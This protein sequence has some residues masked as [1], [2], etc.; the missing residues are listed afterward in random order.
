MTQFKIQTSNTQS[1]F[2]GTKYAYLPAQT[3]TINYGTASNWGGSIN[4]NVTSVGT[5]GNP[6]YYGT[7]DQTG[8]VLEW[9]DLDQTQ[10]TIKGLRGPKNL[11]RIYACQNNPNQISNIRDTNFAKDNDDNL[12]VN[13]QIVTSNN[14][15]VKYSHMVNSGFTPLAAANINGQNRIVFR[16]STLLL[17]QW[18]LNSN[19]ALESSFGW[20]SPKS[21]AY[22]RTESVFETDFDGD[23]IV[24]DPK[25]S[26]IISTIRGLV[27]AKDGNNNLVANGTPVTFQNV[28]VNYNYM[29]ST[30]FTPLAAA[31]INGQN[32]IVFRTNLNFLH[33]WRL[34]SNWNFESSF[35]WQ[36]EGTTPY[37]RSESSFETD[38]NGDGFVPK[39]MRI[40]TPACSMVGG[41][42]VASSSNPGNFFFGNFVT[43]GNP[44]NANDTTNYGQVNYTFLITKYTITNCE[45]IEFL[46]AVASIQDTYSL[47][48]TNMTTDISGGII[49]E[50]NSPTGKFIYKLKNTN[51][52][53]KP[54]TCLTWFN[55]A[56]YCN[57]LHNGKPSIAVYPVNQNTITEDGSY[58][59]NSSS[60][61]VAPQKNS[62]AKYWIP[63]ENEW[64]KA[65]YYDPTLNG[66]N[67]WLF[68][69]RSNNMPMQAK[70]NNIG[71]G[72]IN[73][74]LSSEFTGCESDNTR[75]I[76][77]NFPYN[78]NS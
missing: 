42:R 72:P 20:Q 54:A 63:S 64:Y 74:Y 69:T 7:Y 78:P 71:D 2:E 26:P 11:S 22:Y 47:Y 58:T 31:N 18:R 29:V 49:K 46:N 52:A 5:N 65:A 6:S 66:G 36:A 37:H 77:N 73:P 48:N 3:N 4:G 14:I 25:N 76:L 34:D 61:L 40:T 30:G 23:G 13:G 38:F 50:F 43:V 51:M 67:Y 45:Y 12:T 16:T 62:S 33:H 41:F 27:F 10:N 17:H 68:A 75:Y 60:P 59:M 1:Y 21:T 70:A 53:N 15:P 44:N 39:H 8:N 35:G 28:P 24:G 56:R 9:N 32:R 57:W 19:W 55:C